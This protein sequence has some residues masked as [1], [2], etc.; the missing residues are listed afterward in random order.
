M[1]I[2]MKSIVLYYSATG[3]T[4]TIAEAIHKGMASGVEVCDIASIR[5]AD[6]KLMDKYDLI[7]IGGPIWY[8]R[9]TANLRDFVYNMPDMSGKLAVLYCVHGSGPSGFF[10]SLSTIVKRKGMTII[11]WNDWYG[12]VYQVLHMPKPYLTDGHPDEI[13]QKEAEEFGYEMAARAKRIW[14]GE[15]DLIQKIGAGGYNEPLW[16]VNKFKA[17]QSEEPTMSEEADE[18]TH[19]SNKPVFK[20][21][22]SV[23]KF[24]STECAHPDCSKCIE[25]CPVNAIGSNNNKLSINDGNCLDCALCD[26]LCPQLAIEVDDEAMMHRTKHRIDMTKCTYPECTLCVDYCPMHSIDFTVT[27]PEFK[28]NCEGDDLCWVICPNNAIEILNIE[29]THEPLMIT[30]LADVTDHPF[31]KMLEEEEKKGKFRRHVP[32]S[33]LGFD[34]IICKSTNAPRFVITHE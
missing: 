16:K 30:S 18:G 7:V 1:V 5:K 26:K 6:P 29:T 2:I 28:K 15:R 27:P 13:D 11:G 12:S 9:E 3:N 23:R 10:Y 22:K 4:A 14:A 24:N 21:V 31:E 32:I 33:E 19:K 8:F 34:N 17:Y 20:P 25:I